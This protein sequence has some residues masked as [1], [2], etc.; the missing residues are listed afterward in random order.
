MMTDKK[1]TES[2]TIVAGFLTMVLQTLIQSSVFPESSL[3]PGLGLIGG[4]AEVARNIATF[5]ALYGLRRKLG[6]VG[7]LNDDDVTGRVLKTRSE[8]RPLPLIL[9]VH[10]QAVDQRALQLGQQI[11]RSVRGAV[12]HDDDFQP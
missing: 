2:I 3:E 5:V 8:R 9:L 4:L 10:D 6:E 11:A 7:V 12:V 1:V